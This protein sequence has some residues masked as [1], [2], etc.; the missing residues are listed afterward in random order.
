MVVVVVEA[1]HV[2]SGGVKFPLAELPLAVVVTRLQEAV[3][4][5]KL[6]VSIHT[7]SGSV[8]L[9]MVDSLVAFT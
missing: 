9:S 4:T 2:A 3:L 8:V 6:V 5:H 1:V 7:A